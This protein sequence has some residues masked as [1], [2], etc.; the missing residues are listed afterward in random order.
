MTTPSRLRI[1]VLALVILS[2][3][4]ADVTSAKQPSLKMTGGGRAEYVQSDILGGAPFS[5]R[6][7]SL[8]ASRLDDGTVDRDAQGLLTVTRPGDGGYLSVDVACI[9][10]VP[11]EPGTYLV[12]GL[13]TVDRQQPENVGMDLLV[14]VKDNGNP[15]TGAPDQASLVFTSQPIP[16]GLCDYDADAVL[17]DFNFF[18]GATSFDQLLFFDL[19]G[20]IRAT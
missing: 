20:N 12:S 16:S 6:V 13:I 2:L 1:S 3:A 10:D 14:V 8:S 17:D 7:I 4:S 15:G 19:R 9:K 11:D 5:D 18:F